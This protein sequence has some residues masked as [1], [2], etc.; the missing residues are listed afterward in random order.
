MMRRALLPLLGVALAPP[1]IQAADHVEFRLGNGT[2]IHFTTTTP[3]LLDGEKLPEVSFD[4]R[5]QARVAGLHLKRRIERI[6]GGYRIQLSVTNTRNKPV[7]L[8]ALVPLQITGQSNLLVTGSAVQDWKVFRLARH[9]NDIPGPFRP[10]LLDDASR[11]AASDNSGGSH[12]DDPSRSEAQAIRFHSDPGFVVMADNKPASTHLFIGFDGQTE[13]L[14]DVLI[15]LDHKRT[16]LARLAAVAEFDGAALPPGATRETHPLY[17]QTGKNADLLLSDHVQRIRKRYGARLSKLRNIFC[18]WYF[19]GPEILADD[20]RKDLAEMKRR[21]VQFDTFLIDYNWS[22]NFG[23]WNANPARFPEGMQQI[24][25]E[26]RAAGLAP[27]IWTCPFLIKP[28][29][30]VLRKYP[31]LPLRDRSGKHVRFEMSGMGS[32]YVVDPTAPSAEAFLTELCRKLTG[33]GYRYLKFDFVRAIV[34]NENAQFHDRTMNRAQAYR[35]GMSVLR[36]AAGDTHIG[37]WGGLF[38]A[39]AGIVNI[40]R[41]GSDVRGHWDPFGDYSHETRYPVRMRQT[42]A[43]AFY[44]EKLWT[45]DQDALQLRRR[46]I[47]WRTTRPHLSIGRFT[48]EEAFSTVVYRFL[49]GGVV[50]V[51]EK[52]D[53]LSQDRYDLYKMVIPTYAPVAQR[54]GDWSGYLPEYFVSHF[55]NHKSLPPWAVVTLCNWNGRAPKRLGFAISDVP[56]LPEAARY[57]AFEFKTQKFLGVFKPTDRIELDV[58]THAS[59]VIRLT[60]LPVEGSYLIGGNLNLSCGMEIERTD[61]RQITLRPPVQKVVSEFTYLS[62]KDGNASIDAIKLGRGS[63]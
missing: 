46:S 11:D 53:E 10:T 29:A 6:A 36:A 62:W 60:P 28:D 38:E 13:H 50:Q 61:G 39:N 63:Q 35:R 54:F 43:R 4:G 15:E 17:I 19:Y 34:L 56:D 41:S 33:W 20:L 45:S 25:D 44:D 52:L 12:A 18:T 9:K 2:V 5:S 58:D 59:R 16:A 30:V 27:G 55:K 57:A 26:I 21:P 31:D 1:G 49:G 51:S 48:D 3:I 37:V 7:A 23:D 14:N 24:A 8:R 32:F 40:N 47:P 42:F 22:S